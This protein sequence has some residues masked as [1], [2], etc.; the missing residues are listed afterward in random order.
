MGVS[1]GGGDHVSHPRPVK[2]AHTLGSAWAPS[3][4]SSSRGD[5]WFLLGCSSLLCRVGALVR[6]A[7]GASQASPNL[8]PSFRECRPCYPVSSVR[9]PLF[10]IVCHF[11][12]CLFQEGM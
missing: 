2:A 8:W 12:V 11:F 6:P 9:D 4:A 7:G 3:S 1:P 5:D 10:D